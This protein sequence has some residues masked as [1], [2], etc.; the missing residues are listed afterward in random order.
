MDLVEE[1]Y[2]LIN[3]LPDNENYG[4]R[5]QMQRAVISIPSNIAE[6]QSRYSNKSFV[7]FLTIAKGSKNEIETQ[8]L[9]CQ[10]LNYLDTAQTERALDLC[11]EIGKM[12]H[13]LISKIDAN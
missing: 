11:E 3:L 6:G 13:S 10:R 5:A 7:Q 8:L 9:I 12:L 4:L 1:V 2:R